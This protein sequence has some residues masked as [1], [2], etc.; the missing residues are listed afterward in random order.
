MCLWSKLRPVSNRANNMA[1]TL[2]WKCTCVV[3]TVSA[4]FAN[5]YVLKL[6]DNSLRLL[7]ITILWGSL[8]RWYHHIEELK[9][10]TPSVL[11]VYCQLGFVCFSEVFWGLIFLVSATPLLLASDIFPPPPS[12]LRDFSPSV[13]CEY[14]C[15]KCNLIA[16]GFGNLPQN[17]CYLC[18]HATVCSAT[19]STPTKPS[20][21]RR[22]FWNQP[23]N[24][25]C[26]SFC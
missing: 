7:C 9:S 21:Q 16:K 4:G 6:G 26:K 12:H 2:S 22:G 17:C 23:W 19:K 20:V 13:Y 3:C 1:L 18:S 11:M 10:Q 15:T 5:I 25:I 8:W 14:L 24:S